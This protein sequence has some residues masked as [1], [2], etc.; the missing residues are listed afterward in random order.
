MATLNDVTSAARGAAPRN[1]SDRKLPPGRAD[2]VLP[3]GP[4][5]GGVGARRDPRT[6]NCLTIIGNDC[7]FH[8]LLYSMHMSSAA[9][10]SL[11]LFGCRNVGPAALEALLR[12]AAP[13]VESVRDLARAAARH[14]GLLGRGPQRAWPNE[15]LTAAGLL[16]PP[17]GQPKKPPTFSFHPPGGA[18]AARAE[19]QRLREHRGGEP[20]ENRGQLPVIAASPEQGLDAETREPLVEPRHD[21]SRGVGVSEVTQ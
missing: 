11:N 16:L 4:S 15:K 5:G 17:R 10:Q 6:T 2:S 18:I 14:C 19:R 9:L 13:P 7:I 12:V 3:V 1:K 20:R 21:S 8:A